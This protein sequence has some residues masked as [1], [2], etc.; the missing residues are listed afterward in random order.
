MK[1]KEDD[2]CW[3][4]AK[5]QFKPIFQ[6]GVTVYIQY[7]TTVST[8]QKEYNG[9]EF[10]ILLFLKALTPKD[11][12]FL[13][14]K[15]Y[16]L[17][18]NFLQQYGVNTGWKSIQEIINQTYPPKIQPQKVAIQPS[19]YRKTSPNLIEIQAAL[20][21]FSK[22]GLQRYPVNTSKKTKKVNYHRKPRHL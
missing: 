6:K 1:C 22:S 12:K 9:K 3:N 17:Q 16:I 7:K 8:Q 15:C 18:E 4:R 5:S 13:P 10:D 20:Q 11:F 21:Q 14:L 19:T 2:L